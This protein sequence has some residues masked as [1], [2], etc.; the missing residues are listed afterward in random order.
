[1]K[2]APGRVSGVFTK[3]LYGVYSTLDKISRTAASSSDGSS[4]GGSI[5]RMTALQGTLSK[6]RT[7]L[8]SKQEDLRVKLVSRYAALNTQVSG[9]QSTLSFLQARFNNNNGNNN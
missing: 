8:E 2:P 3:C 5:S 4:I 1:M 9:A 6:K 7:T